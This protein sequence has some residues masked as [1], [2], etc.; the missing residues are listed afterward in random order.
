VPT[1]ARERL[2]FILPRAAEARR[3]SDPPRNKAR[4]E[5]DWLR[6]TGELAEFMA[7]RNISR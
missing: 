4:A 3:Y 7:E 5:V 1:R 2:A 6:M